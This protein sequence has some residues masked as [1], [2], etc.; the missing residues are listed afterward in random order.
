MIDKKLSFSD[1]ERTEES[2]VEDIQPK[3]K[4][5]RKRKKKKRKK[6]SQQASKEGGVTFGSVSILQLER[7]LGSDTVPKNGGWPLGMITT[8]IRRNQAETIPIEDYETAKQERLSERWRQKQQTEPP[9]LLETR[10]IDYRGDKNPLF[11]S[12]DEHERQSLLTGMPVSSPSKS[13]PSS[14]SSGSHKQQRRTRSKSFSDTIVDHPHHPDYPHDVVQHVQHELE[15]VRLSR[16]L[17]VGCDCKPFKTKKKSDHKLREELKRRHVCIPV[18][19][20]R[21]ELEAALAQAGCCGPD[22]SCVYGCQADACGCWKHHSSKAATAEEITKACGNRM[23]AVDI[24]QIQAYREAVLAKLED[25][26][27]VEEDDER[28][29]ES[30]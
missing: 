8:R 22:C 4:S 26:V 17:Q 9:A 11:R 16:V 3:K 20:T 29:D 19:A 30:Y 18:D 25:R 1:T 28:S 21:S 5:K 13:P 10:Q 7:C 14:T 6:K 23:Y 15:Q 27:F 12:L 2:P 24:P